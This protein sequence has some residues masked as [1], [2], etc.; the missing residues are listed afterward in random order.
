MSN[1]VVYA[2]IGGL[3]AHGHFIR[4]LKYGCWVFMILKAVYTPVKHHHANI[5]SINKNQN[6]IQKNECVY[7]HLYIHTYKHT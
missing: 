7:V 2:S 5:Q 4:Q 6:E 3:I 1:K